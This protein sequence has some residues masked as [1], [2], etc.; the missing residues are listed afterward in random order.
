[1]PEVLKRRRQKILKL[2][3]ARHIL[4]P[5][6][7]VL[8]LLF[9]FVLARD[10]QRTSQKYLQDEF[11]FR[12]RDL[13]DQLEKRM[14]LYEQVLR[15]TLGLF[16]VTGQVSRDDFRK[17]VETLQLQR[18]YPGIEGIGF[19]LLVPASRKDAHVRE[20]RRSGFPQ[21][22][23]NPAGQR[24]V[25]TSIVYL[26]PFSGRNLR[27][28]GFDMYSEEHR[29]AAMDQARDRNQAAITKKVTLV[30]EGDSDVDVQ[31]G[32][33]MYLPVYRNGTAHETVLERR[34]NL[35]G[36]VYAPFR[37]QDL[38]RGIE[39]VRTKELEVK[40][41]DGDKP[42]PQALMYDSHRSVEAS[43]HISRFRQTEKVDVAGHRWLIVMSSL[44]PY[45]QQ[46]RADRA[47]LILRGGIS[48]SLLLALL[49]WLFLDDRARALHAADQAMRLALYDALTGL[50]N[51]KLLHER[52]ALALLK[53]R[54]DN[55]MIALLFIDLDKF[56]PVNDE[57]GHAIGD[58]LLKEVAMR[59]QHCMRASDT[60]ARVGGDEFIA[61]LDGIEGR[62][63]AGKVANKILHAVTQPFEVSGHRL[64]IAAS[65]GVAM[66]PDNGEDES[67]LIKSADMAMYEAK[68]NGRSTICFATKKSGAA[69]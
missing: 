43:D 45:E 42:E 23:I 61:L 68:N 67:V 32:F 49:V 38:M 1:L 3:N 27:A 44:P 64:E 40:I 36:W 30:Q 33:L 34:E 35:V 21:Y 14:Q 58:L 48:I 63:G 66:F 7:L 65:I 16:V 31:T 57:Y 15:G 62:E 2:F 29:R 22:D 52:L 8:S 37:M 47:A 24:E 18:N 54:R 20:L 41:Y 4:P 50:P 17:Y 11:S 13:S 51:R 69:G 28:F 19:S 59:L 53:A 55:G 56:K 46:E 12:V 25:Y 39:G 26:E 6:I 60:M 5:V 10:A 9:T